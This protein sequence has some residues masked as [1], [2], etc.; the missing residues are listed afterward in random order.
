MLPGRQ[1]QD[2]GTP[3]RGL[4]SGPVSQPSEA[5]FVGTFRVQ[6]PK[7]QPDGVRGLHRPTCRR[8]RSVTPLLGKG[9][10]WPFATLFNPLPSAL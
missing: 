7:E 3:R 1:A 4:S 8:G 6:L 10:H 5:S 2:L 9:G